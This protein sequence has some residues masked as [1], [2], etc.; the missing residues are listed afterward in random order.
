MGSY[1]SSRNCDG[2][3]DSDQPLS[4]ERD[5]FQLSFYKNE[6]RAHCEQFLL[7]LFWSWKKSQTAISSVKNQILKFRSPSWTIPR[8]VGRL[9]VL[10]SKEWRPDSGPTAL[11][12]VHS[13]SPMHPEE[14]RLRVGLGPA[15]LPPWGSWAVSLPPPPLFVFQDKSNWNIDI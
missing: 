8:C 1:L 5:F 14:A 13:R 7:W 2:N 9:P 15:L 3:I 6:R 10:R 4:A 12:V 11:L